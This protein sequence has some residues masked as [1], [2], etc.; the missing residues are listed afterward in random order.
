MLPETLIYHQL[1]KSATV[2]LTKINVFF[3]SYL[4]AAFYYLL[5]KLGVRW[6]GNVFLLDRGVNEYFFLLYFFLF[7]EADTEP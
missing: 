3:L 5:M 4:P 1:A 6:I 2:A 7:K